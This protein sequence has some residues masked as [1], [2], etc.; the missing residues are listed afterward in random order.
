MNLILLLSYTSPENLGSRAFR[1]TV[2]DC[3]KRAVCAT[4][5]I[6]ADDA[7]TFFVNGK[8]VGSGRGLAAADAW[9]IPNLEPTY[10]VFAINGTNNLPVR[11][12]V[13]GTILITYSDGT[14]LT[15]VTDASWLVL[16]D[17][18]EGFQEMIVDE[19]GF[20]AATELA[21]FGA[22]TWHIPTIPAA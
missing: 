8:V 19:S 6:N 4:A 3:T 5:V 12:A 15:I 14:T 7:Y 9:S 20:T 17:A 16:R 21:K 22:P 1:K 18:S 10:N 11:G 2:S 13:V